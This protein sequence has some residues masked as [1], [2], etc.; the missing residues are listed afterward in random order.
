MEY[1]NPCPFCGG[2]AES[3]ETFAIA[4]D[5]ELYW[6]V[7]CVRCWAKS[8]F[9]DT[10]EKAIAA[11]NTRAERT[12]S[13]KNTEKPYSIFFRCSYCGYPNTSAI[14]AQILAADVNYCP[15][16]GALVKKAV[17]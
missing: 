2:K 10:K 14:D 1:L 5:D 13:N 12:C 4:N 15:S 7:S 9:C 17:E 8:A 6:I 16:C 11:W 3:F